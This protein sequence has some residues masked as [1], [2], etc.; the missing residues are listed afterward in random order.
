MLAK[1]RNNLKNS[2]KYQILY[3]PT[4]EYQ[5]DNES[6]RKYGKGYML[7]REATRYFDMNY[8]SE[9]AK[10]SILRSPGLATREEL[11]DLPPALLVVAEADVLRCGTHIIARV[12][13]WNNEN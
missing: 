7:T 4:V 5:P 6:Y 12:F 8:D 2:I 9:S 1:Q 10:D 13:K 11:M 3:Y